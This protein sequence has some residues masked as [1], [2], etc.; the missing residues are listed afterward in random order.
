MSDTAEL[1]RQLQQNAGKALGKI[2]QKLDDPH[3]KASLSQLGVVA[4]I[5]LDKAQLLENKPTQIVSVT[6][7]LEIDEVTKLLIQELGR[8]G[9]TIE[10][11]AVEVD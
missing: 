4:G 10:G 2:Q 5:M 3:D 7:R 6:E 1:I 9:I 11:E 8:R